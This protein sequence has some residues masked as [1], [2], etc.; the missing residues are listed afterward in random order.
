[1]VG[2]LTGVLLPVKPAS[3]HY[4]GSSGLPGL[5]LI[6]CMWLSSLQCQVLFSAPLHEVCSTRLLVCTKSV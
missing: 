5:S 6:L 1:M 2:S 3:T 4:P